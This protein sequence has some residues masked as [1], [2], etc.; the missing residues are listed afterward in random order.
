MNN[1][2]KIAQAAVLEDMKTIAAKAGIDEKYLE[3]YGNDK[4]KLSN[5]LKETVKDN[6]DGKL[7]LVTAINPTKAG[8]GKSTT[9]IG[10]ADGLAKAGKNVMACLRE[11]SLGPVFVR[12]K[13]STCISQVICMPSQ[14]PTTLSQRFWTTPFSRAIR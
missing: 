6:P 5:E 4:A 9:T 11:P 14:Q 12:W 10:L 13:Q 2:L 3:P 7:I 1:D 8:E